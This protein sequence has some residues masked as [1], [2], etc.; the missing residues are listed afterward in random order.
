MDQ[1]QKK[2]ILIMQI[3]ATILVIFI[4]VI[5]IINLKNVWRADKEFATKN[6]DQEWSNLKNDLEKTL[7]EVQNQMKQINQT[8][9]EQESLKNR[10]FLSDLVAETKN[11]PSPPVTSTTTATSSAS[12]TGTPPKVNRPNCPE[13]INCM[14]T[15]GQA[16]TCQI[17]VGCEGITQIAY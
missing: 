3:G 5:W 13:W 7:S 11:L 14:P 2:K 4:L 17:P 1:N 15:I 10:S 9:K 6:D 16:R 8:R 12:A